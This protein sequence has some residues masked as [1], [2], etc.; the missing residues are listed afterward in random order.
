M[1]RADWV[2]PT[3]VTIAIG[4]GAMLVTL[5]VVQRTQQA[6]LAQRLQEMPAAQREATMKLAQAAGTVGTLAGL[7]LMTLVTLFAAGM[8]PVVV[9]TDAAGGYLF[10][11][12]P[13]GA[14]TVSV[15]PPPGFMQT[16]DLDG[17][18]TPNAAA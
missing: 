18:G 1:T 15:T 11:N 10:T 12:L 7:P 5:P 14:Y 8:A 16:Y 6:L 2:V 9:H 3:A 13:A 4:V 17:L